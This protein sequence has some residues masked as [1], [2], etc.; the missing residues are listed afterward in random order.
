M[1]KISHGNSSQQSLIILLLTVIIV[2]ALVLNIVLLI[3]Y[4]TASQ[5]QIYVVGDVNVTPNIINGQDLDFT[6]DDLMPGVVIERTLRIQSEA[7]SPNFY[8][9]VT[10]I[11]KI[12][13]IAT[14]DVHTTIDESRDLDW[15]P[16]S[17]EIVA[18]YYY[19]KVFLAAQITYLHL[20]FN[21]SESLS[22][23]SQGKNL[24]VLLYVET[25][26]FEAGYANWENLPIGW[27]E[28]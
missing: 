15:L 4:G 13:G 22:Q 20:E 2:V 28:E 9:R 3:F 5:S 11:F 7:T 6:S 8:L 18:Y 23:S 17:Q 19:N 10:T 16:D 12:D 26:S 25:T 21:I 27:L 1:Q 14:S 24:S